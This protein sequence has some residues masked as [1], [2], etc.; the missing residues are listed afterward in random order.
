MRSTLD[1]ISPVIIRWKLDYQV[2][3]AESRGD[4]RRRRSAGDPESQ[5]SV[6]FFKG[7]IALLGGVG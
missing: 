7:G 3:F 6:G 5:H 2:G 1:L 4:F